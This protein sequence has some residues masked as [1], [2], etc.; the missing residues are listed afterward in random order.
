LAQIRSEMGVGTN[1]QILLPRITNPIEKKL[2]PTEIVELL[3]T[4]EGKVV[5]VVDDEE[6]ARMQMTEFLRLYGFETMEAADGASALVLL[7]SKNHIDLMISDIGLPGGMNG[8]QMA[9][10]ARILRPG[11]KVLFITG[12][13]KKA[14]ME[15]GQLPHGVQLLAKPFSLKEMVIKATGMISADFDRA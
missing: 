14:F 3:S 5:L 13:A 11:L 1:V 9:D 6:N 2:A 10:I 7:E 12:Y 8:R 15:N 4:G